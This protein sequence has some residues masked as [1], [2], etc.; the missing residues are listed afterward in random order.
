VAVVLKNGQIVTG[1]FIQRAKNNRWIEVKQEIA[2]DCELDV[3]IQRAEINSMSVI[4]GVL[5]L[6]RL[7]IKGE[8]NG[9]SSRQVRLRN[10]RS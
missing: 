7:G 9:K 2:P 4:K 5:D 3:R 6:K 8:K 1:K 10:G